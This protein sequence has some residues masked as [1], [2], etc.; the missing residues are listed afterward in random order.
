MRNLVIGSSG[1]VGRYLCEYLIK[2]GESVVQYDIVNN[3]FEDCRHCRLYLDNI[4]RVYLLAWKVGGSNYLYDFKTQKEQLDWNIKILCNTMDQLNNVPFV[5]VSSQLAEN[6]DTV[7]GVLKRLGEVWSE[8]NG[9]VVVRLWNVYGA[10]EHSS[11]RSHV[12]A[13]FVHQALKNGKIVMQTTGDEKRQFVHIEDVCDALYAS[14][15]HKGIYDVSSLQWHSVY[16]VASL[17]AS[18]TNCNIIAGSQIGSSLIIPNKNLVPGCVP[19]VSLIDGIGRTIELF[20][21]CQ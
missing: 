2:K 9:G 1:F 4:D 18:Y 21:S 11:I 10:F 14:F 7:Y 12:V 6:C 16:N 20:K 3:E 15:I 19:K 13:D 5:F 17:I 8:L